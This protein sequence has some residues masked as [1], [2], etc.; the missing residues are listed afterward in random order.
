[1]P[2]PPRDEDHR[3]TGRLTYQW[4]AAGESATRMSLRNR[5]EPAGFR[6]VAAPF[7]SAAMRRANQKD[8]VRLKR[9]LE[10]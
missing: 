9:L 10:A 2:Q 8:L 6:S 7:V 4:A 5:G 3:P 1:M